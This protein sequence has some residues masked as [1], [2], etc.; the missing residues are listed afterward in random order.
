MTGALPR[1]FATFAPDIVEHAAI[2]DPVAVEL[3]QLAGGHV[4]ALAQRLL[5]L[6]VERLSLVGGLAAPLAPWLADATRSASLR[7]SATPSTARCSWRVRRQNRPCI[8][9]AA[10][11]AP[12]MSD[13]RRNMEAEW[14]EAP[15]AVRRQGAALA[16]PLAELAAPHPAQSAAASCVTCARGS[17]AHAATFGK[18]LIERHLG[19]PVA[20]RRAQ[21]RDRSTSSGSRSRASSSSRSR[22]PD[23]A[24]TSSSSAAMAKAAG[25]LTAAIVNDTASP[26]ARASRHRAADG[27]GARA[28]RRR[29]PRSSSRASR[30]CCMRLTAAWAE[31]TDIARGGRATAG[32]ARGRRRARLE[33]SAAVVVG[34]DEPGRRSDAA[35]PWRSRGRLR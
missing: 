25:A 5:A 6:G 32:S 24:T 9:I 15:D 17:S 3:M 10:V 29:R 21:Y 2:H 23:A 35:P 16:A 18:H 26:L 11:E 4:D 12:P 8:T 30:P 27:G 31:L 22:S 14:Q 28:Q 33:R 1:D 13:P 20:R 34:G 7:R 19:I